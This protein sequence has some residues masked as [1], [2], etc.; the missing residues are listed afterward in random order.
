MEWGFNPSSKDKWLL[1]RLSCRIDRLTVKESDP[2]QL[3]CKPEGR[4][5][6]LVASTQSGASKAAYGER[7]RSR[8]IKRHNDTDRQGK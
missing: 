2:L 8:E 1:Y 7:E 5:A 3:V 4:H 6:R